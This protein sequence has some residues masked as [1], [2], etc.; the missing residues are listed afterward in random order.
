MDSEASITPR[1]YRGTY[2]ILKLYGQSSC[3]PAQIEEEIQFLNL[4]FAVLVCFGC[5]NQ[6]SKT[7]WL[8]NTRNLILTVLILS[9]LSRYGQIWCL[10]IACFLVDRAQSCCCVLSRQTAW[11]S[12]PGS[13]V[14][15][16]WSHL[17]CSTFMT[18]S[19]PG[20]VY[21]QIPSHWRLGFKIQILGGY[22][23]SDSFSNLT[24]V[25]GSVKKM[26]AYIMRFPGSV[27]KPIFKWIFSFLYLCY[28]YTGQFICTLSSFCLV[29]G[30]FLEESWLVSFKSLQDREYPGSFRT[31]NEL[32]AHTYY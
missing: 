32:Y 8:F 22:K 31:I 13:L 5:H 27:P 2:K 16:H 29:C 9:P 30:L 20:S 17:W 12:S 10:G 18:Q 7:G 24:E 21:F 6:L 11:G 25:L 26:V 19:P 1:E 3:K 23:H 4:M 28:F 14:E 15:G